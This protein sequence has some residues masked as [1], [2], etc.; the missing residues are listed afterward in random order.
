MLKFIR[1]KGQQPTAERQRLQK[2]LFAYR[3]TA[4]H[5]FPHKPSAL[6]YD[7][8][9]KLMAIGTQTG[10]IKVLGQPGVELYGQH[11]LVNNSTSELNVQLLEWVYGSGR[12]LSLTAANQLILWEPVGI[13][14]VPIK[15]LPFDGKLKKVSSLCCSLSKDLVWIGTEGGNI[16]QFDLKSFTIREPVIYH[17][18]VLEQV[19]PTYKLNPGAIESIRQLPNELNKLLIAYNRGLCVLWDMDM[20]SVER[21]YIAPGHGQ[22]V[23]L[24][25]NNT[26]TEFTWYHADG[27]YA[28]WLIASGEPPENV[29]YV[30]YG[31]DPCKSINR[32]YK[33]KRSVNDV[34]IFSGGMPRSAYG[35]HNCV[36]VHSSDGKKI[37]LDFTSKVIDFFVTY[38]EESE[39]LQVLVVLLEEE[40]CAY[41][42]TDAK[43]PAIKA[44]YLH[45]VHAS[46]VTCNYIASQVTQTVYKRIKRAGGEQDIEFSSID[47]PVTGG[48]LPEGVAQCDEN[49]TTKEYEILLTG[50]EDGSVKFWD[51]SGVLLHPIYN[52]KTANIFGHENHDETAA[53]EC[54]ELDESEPPFRKAGL[55]D[56]YSD[57]PRLAVKKIALCPKTGHLIV[58][59]TAGQIVIA[60]FD[61]DSL[62]HVM[63]KLSSMNLVS[64]RDGFVWKGHDQLNVRPNLL[65]EDSL[66]ISENGVNITGVLQVLPP[67]SITCLALE[68]NWGLVSGGTAHGLVLFD[69]KNFVPVFHRC[70]LNPNDLTGA[71]EQLSRRKSFKKSLRE[72]F[73]KLRKGRSTRNNPSNQVPT[74]LEARPVERQIE[75]RCTDDGMGSMVRCLL[76]AKTYITNVNI[77]S[78]TLWSATN[79]STVS[80]FLLHLP[81][82]QT[83]ATTGPPASGN[84]TPQSPRR[85]SAQLAKEIQ[86]KHRAPVIGISIF[87]QSGC[88]VDQLNYGENGTPPHRVLIAS[89]EQFKVFSLPQLKPINKYK[90]TAH[91]GARIRRIH[92]GSFSC[93]VSHELL[94]SLTGSSPTKSTRSNDGG[95]GAANTSLTACNSEIYHEMALICLT[96]MGDIMVLS[97]PELK[98]QLNAAAVR[99][100]DI[101]GISSL[102]FTNSGE[103]LYMM[104]SSELQRIAL[105]TFRVVQPT[106]MVPVEPFESEGNESTMPTNEDDNSDKEVDSNDD[107]TIPNPPIAKQ[108]AKAL[109]L[110]I[111]N[112]TSPRT[113]GLN[114]SPNRANETITSSIGDLTVDSVRDHLNTTTTTLCSTTTEET[115]GRLSVLS[116]QTNHA[117][118]S[119]N[120]KDIPNINIPNLFDLASKGNTTESSTSSVV[121]KSVITSISHEKTNGKN[122]TLKTK[123]TEHEESQF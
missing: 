102:C 96:N 119:V 17:D 107:A 122:E 22:S 29:N 47:W 18:V 75:A 21:A 114:S 44:P 79:A 8:V 91:E 6:A 39:D 48:V 73:R 50:H 66:P 108:R 120:I 51:C 118:A 16:Y 53:V 31:P 93:R 34:I 82:A 9:S 13:T 52:F 38:K 3:K 116:T 89:E 24:Y 35:D 80:V 10:A 12:L 20:S 86:L 74:T 49:E 113:N 94:Q 109:E 110:S 72:S 32:L 11:T 71:G 23:G 28:S 5:G 43:V 101:N 88:P 99:R 19:P 90:L 69:F 37:C 77:T 85:I 100:E 57:D 117:T 61:G 15:T 30:P 81:P 4:Q 45:S 78:P 2:E 65:G 54:N 76:F 106:G 36:S 67:A 70:T 42:L 26:G 25:V 112:N 46:A 123:S 64:D 103:A 58:G 92:F 97:V 98:R 105:A 95:D 59:G 41:D 14:L 104:S 115:V 55:F 33:G 87:D 40:F 56:P 63:L 121:I 1:G 60:D 68:A 111:E 84:T 83:A 27:S 62:E 7:P